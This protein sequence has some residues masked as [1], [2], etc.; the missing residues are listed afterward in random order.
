M[1]YFNAA[2]KLC[3]H[4]FTNSLLYAFSLSLSLYKLYD[5]LVG[6]PPINSKFDEIV[7]Y[8]LS[9]CGYVDSFTTGIICLIKS[10]C[11]IAKPWGHPIHDILFWHHL[12]KEFCLLKMIHIIN[13]ISYFVFSRGS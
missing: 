6:H 7:Q 10:Y 5:K 3:I 13:I 1:K 9:S 2:N 12:V 11:Y 4:A 8:Q